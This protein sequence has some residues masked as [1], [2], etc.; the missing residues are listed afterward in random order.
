MSLPTPGTPIIIDIGSAYVKVGFAGEI[1]PRFIFPCITGTEKYHSVMVDVDARN[2]Y[3]GQDAMKMRGVLKIAHPIQRGAIVDWDSYYQILNHILYTLL[4]IQNPLDYPI[5]Y[6]EN[7]FQPKDIKEYI[8]R[9]FF[10]THQINNLIMVPSPILSCFSVGLTSGLV[11]ESGD[12]ITWIVPII[13]GQII[14]QA[15][16]RLNLA[17][18]DVSNNLKALLMREG[19]NISSSAV[20]EIIKE[21]KEKNCYFILDPDKPSKGGENIMYPMPDGSTVKIPDHILYSATEVLFQPS[22]IGSNSP[23]IQHAIITCLQNV[24]QEYWAD[25][26]SHVVLS[27][28]NLSHSGFEERLKAEL[29]IL[30]PQYGISFK[31]KKIEKKKEEKLE[32]LKPIEGTKK[33]QDTCSQ[34]G[35]L[36]DLADGKTNCPQCG[37]N[38]KIPEIK[39]E[40]DQSGTNTELKCSKCKKEISDNDSL[41]CPYCGNNL[42]ITSPAIPIKEIENAKKKTSETIGFSEY[43]DSSKSGIRFF[44]PNNLQLAVYNGATILGSLPSFRNLFVTKEQFEINKEI[45]HTDIS[46]IF[47]NYQ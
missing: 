34:C 17:G 6:I 7:T 30:L 3:V 27:G 11:I 39:I 23:G 44:I 16:Q 38:M 1:N 42:K 31:P 46:Q 45:L 20:D 2:V 41:F 15:V 24:S 22:M 12:G 8:A 32:T 35:A 37:A 33:N 5:I 13:N 10:E 18:M 36:I 4:R 21:I 9:V 19:I 25:L 40:I 26:L 29:T 43:T 28:G 14:S 47:A